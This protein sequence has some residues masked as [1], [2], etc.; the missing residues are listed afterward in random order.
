LGGG[1][2]DRERVF[3][4]STTHGAEIPAL[5]AAMATIRYYKAHPVI[6]TLYARGERLRSGLQRAI[7]ELKLERHFSLASRDCNLIFGTRDADGN[8]SQSFR[9]FF[10]QELVARGVIAP[11]FVVSFSHT[12]K[13]IDYTVD[14][15]SEALALYRKALEDGIEG[16]LEGR[17]VKPAFRRF[18]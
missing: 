6:E 8:P 2:H 15:A 4:L 12:E 5:S 1:D 10:M 7:A 17:A 11:S 18:A 16:Y 14:A 13:D 3:L 9:T